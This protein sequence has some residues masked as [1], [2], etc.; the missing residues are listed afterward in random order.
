MIHTEAHGDIGIIAPSGH[1]TQ[2]EF[3]EAVDR[4]LSLCPGGVARG[5]V[6]DFANASGV[7]RHSVVRIRET[8]RHLADHRH[9]Y[10][11]RAAV[12]ATHEEV[13]RV[14]NIGGVISRG[15]GIDYRFC[16]D[17]DE[18]LRWLLTDDAHHPT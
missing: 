4:V 9:R 15:Q 5:L 7:E 8:T 2:V 18:A 6:M 13:A 12:I 17:R 10:A 14:M 1:Y 11:S 3:A 16:A